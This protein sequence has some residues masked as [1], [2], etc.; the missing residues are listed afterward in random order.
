MKGK[1]LAAVMKSVKKILFLKFLLIAFVCN[2]FANR[3]NPLTGKITDENGAPLS[4]A[5]VQVKGTSLKTVTDATGGFYLSDVEPNATITVSHE[6]YVPLDVEVN[7]KTDLVVTLRKKKSNV[8]QIVV[9][10]YGTARKKDI[11]SA[12]STVSAKDAGQTAATN[13]AQ[14]LIGKAAGVQILNS[15]GVPGAGTQIIIRG[16]G[17]F[18][19]VSPLFVIDGIQGDINSI[20][21]QDI[22]NITV[23][24]DASSTAIYGSAAANGVVIVTTKRAKSGAPRITYTSKIGV[25]SA[26]RQ[27]DMLKTK[28]YLEL[29]KDYAASKNATLPAKLSNG[30]LGDSTDWQKE[31]FRNAMFTENYLSVNGGTDKV[32]YNFS[33]GYIT[34][35]SIVQDYKYDRL[36]LKLGLEETVGRFRFGQ[37]LN[38]RYTKSKGQIASLL[39]AI[40]YVPYKPIRDARVEGGY[41]IVTNGEDLTN[42]INPLQRLG[43]VSS[44]GNEY[45]LFPQFF[46]EVN[47]IKG[48]KFRSQA[49]FTIGGNTSESYQ[50]PY[51]ASNNLRYDR[52][53]SLGTGRYSTYTFENYMSYNKSIGK[54]NISL[55]AGN[56]YID[57]GNSSYLETLGTGLVN[58]NIQ[59][60]SVAPTKT[61]TRADKGYGTQFGTLISYFGRAVYSFDDKYF[62]SASV[63]RDGSSNFGKNN[64]FGNFPGVG[65]AWKF[66]EEDF[67]KNNTSFISDGKL[68]VGWGRTGNNRINLFLTDA[69]T[70]S[71]APNGNL[72]YSFGNT[73]TFTAGTTIIGQPNPNLKWE[74]T[75]QTDIGLDVAFFDSKLNLT[76]DWYNRKSSGL[77]VRVPIPTSNGIG[78]LSG[79]GSNYISNAADAQNKGLEISIGYRNALKNGLT[80]N[81]SVNGS[82]NNNKVL[83]LGNQFQAP[84]K[85]GAVFKIDAMTYTAKGSPIGSFFGYV[86][87]RVARD[88]SDI[89]ALNAKS[90]TGTYQTGLLPGDFIF[91]DLDGNNIVNADDQ[92]ILGNPMPKF[93][94]G[95]NGG[96]SFKNF[97]INL[98]ISG[99][100]GVKLLNANR[101]F[102]A[103]VEEG[104]NATTEILNRWR[105]PGDV[106][107]LPRAGQST[108]SNGNIRPSDFYIE[109][110]DYMRVRNLTIGYNI[111]Q[112]FINSIG[113]GKVFNSLRIYISSEN[114]LTITKYKGY[115]PEV[116]TQNSGGGDAYIFRRGIDVGQLPQPRIFMGGIQ[117]GF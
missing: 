108:G 66:S 45:V 95:I 53:A 32:L 62:L 55:T 35:K 43:V 2:A 75:D 60:V 70:Y 107:A 52:Q 83:S 10:G 51:T 7:G 61:V 22:E 74:Q 81:I 97:D 87:D 92:K 33:A 40:S 77:L 76:V 69:S 68:R 71:G 12:V 20:S 34:Q 30:S 17:S 11:V 26:W 111:P 5:T 3:G 113:N 38:V 15:N 16:T 18:T 82:F 28:D 114:L 64:R 106:A 79:F 72:V 58:D 84:I 103:N 24:K 59:N 90:P 110:G 115:D 49:A 94:Y 93:T 27:L 89:A 4:S 105:K 39:N 85:D 117:V 46:G 96:V 57:A 41:S 116:S 100:S 25:A 44:S 63:R 98:V 56:S 21:P 73:E 6:D 88:A 54:H 78:G 91:K 112:K 23:L 31:I 37:S 47:I 99:I 48:L 102:T 86:V 42:A 9:I 67:V 19:N 8:D 101:Y 104:H 29:I 1:R 14:L 80:Y 36:N 109:N 65:A 50:K 13:P